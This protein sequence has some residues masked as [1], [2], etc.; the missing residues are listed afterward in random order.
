MPSVLSTGVRVSFSVFLSLDISE[1]NGT[2]QNKVEHFLALVNNV[3][4]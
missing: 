1:C 4:E 3:N 2:T